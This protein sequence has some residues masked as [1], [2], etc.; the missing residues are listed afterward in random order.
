MLKLEATVSE[1]TYASCL[2]FFCVFAMFH[3]SLT[4]VMPKLFFFFLWLLSEKECIFHFSC[5]PRS[6]HHH[7]KNRQV[8][9][10]RTASVTS[11]VKWGNNSTPFQDRDDDWMRWS[12]KHFRVAYH[13]AT[14]AAVFHITS[15]VL[16]IVI[17]MMQRVWWNPIRIWLLLQRVVFRRMGTESLDYLTDW[18]G[19]FL[20]DEEGI[21]YLMLF[22]LIHFLSCPHPHLPLFPGN[23]LSPAGT[24]VDEGVRS[25][26]KRI[27]APPGGRSNITSL[28]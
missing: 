28:S 12:E 22:K 6:D 4:T 18:N 24:Q 2:K 26:S 8:A 27:V 13:S 25:A 17:V 19:S 20:G 15:V 3:C 1:I 10:S 7:S 14:W 11:S 5:I 21:Y 9:W 23:F 16:F